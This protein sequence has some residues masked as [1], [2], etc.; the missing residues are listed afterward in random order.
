MHTMF[1]G[2][3]T[4]LTLTAM[5]AN[6]GSWSGFLHRY[7]GITDKALGVDRERQGID[8]GEGCWGEWG[9]PG[10]PR[11][12]QVMSKQNPSLRRV[13]GRGVG[14][15]GLGGAQVEGEGYSCGSLFVASVSLSVPSSHNSVWCRVCVTLLYVYHYSATGPDPEQLSGLKERKEWFSG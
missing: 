6:P 14:I 4:A 10:K 7:V 3:R 5:G 9:Y 1:L 2:E 13:S 11:L 15:C 8:L 12:S